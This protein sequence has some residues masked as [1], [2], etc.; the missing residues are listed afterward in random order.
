MDCTVAVL[1]HPALKRLCE[2]HPEVGMRLLM[3]LG[4]DVSENL[5]MADEKL[6]RLAT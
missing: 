4:H 1:K 5:H 6:R 2:K 3:K